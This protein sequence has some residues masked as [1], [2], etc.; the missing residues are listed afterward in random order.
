MLILH[1]A[2]LPFS[3][4]AILLKWSNNVLII[5]ILLVGVG[6]TWNGIGAVSLKC[7][8]WISFTSMTTN[9]LLTFESG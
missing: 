7:R 8:F 3:C 6:K 5:L 9:D 4:E 2:L 1:L